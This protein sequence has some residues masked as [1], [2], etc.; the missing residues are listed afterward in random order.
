MTLKELA[1]VFD[2]IFYKN[3]ALDRDKTGLRIGNIQ[4]DISKI[5]IT[6]DLTNAAIQEA[7]RLKVDLLLSHHPLSNEP[8]D[9]FLDTTVLGSKLLD[10]IKNNI[11]VYVAHT[12]YD[13]MPGGLNVLF[14]RKL[15]FAASAAGPAGT[16]PAFLEPVCADAG[17]AR[18]ASGEGGFGIIVELDT[19]I[20]LPVFFRKIKENLSISGFRWITSKRLKSAAAMSDNLENMLVKKILIINGSANSFTQRIA[21]SDFDC[22]VVIVGELGY[23][24]SLEIAESGKIIIEIGHGDSEKFAVEGMYDILNMYFKENGI[25]EIEVIKSKEGYKSWR[26]YIG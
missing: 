6:L 20:K 19:P 25:K 16:K 18:A 23:H 15:G 10:I 17:A 14:A 8:I 11:A 24:G 13:I 12:N 22:D 4:K 1:K 5:L 3:L 21:V 26:Y 9:L 7:I 2:R